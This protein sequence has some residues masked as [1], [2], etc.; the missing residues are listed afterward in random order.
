LSGKCL[1]LKKTDCFPALTGV[2]YIRASPCSSVVYKLC[3]LLI[4]LSVPHAMCS[5][6]THL[7]YSL[8]P[9]KHKQSFP[10]ISQMLSFLSTFSVVRIHSSQF[11]NYSRK[12]LLNKN[13]YLFTLCCELSLRHS[14]GLNFWV[15]CFCMGYDCLVN[16]LLIGSSVSTTHED[17]SE[18]MHC[19]FNVSFVHCG[20]CEWYYKLFL[21]TCNTRHPRHGCGA[22]WPAGRYLLVWVLLLLECISYCD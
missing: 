9:L 6:A 10:W 13:H 20:A 1:F 12:L 21:R 17:H 8:W 7:H 3:W 4:W 11:K 19:L 18:G 5:K 22:I 15:T 2:L 16:A 14:K